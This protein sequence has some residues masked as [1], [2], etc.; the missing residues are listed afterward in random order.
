M[1]SYI[2]YILSLLKITH[3]SFKKNYSEF[4]IHLFSF[5]SFEQF[6]LLSE[7]KHK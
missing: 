3:T 1:S 2:L 7:E 6:E 5:I 4:L